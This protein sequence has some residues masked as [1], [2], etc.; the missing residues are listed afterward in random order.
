[1]T[2]RDRASGFFRAS[3]ANWI[4]WLGWIVVI[5]V[6]LA[7]AIAVRE[8]GES[9]FDAYHRLPPLVRIGLPL[10]V[11]ALLLKPLYL[12]VIRRHDWKSQSGRDAVAQTILEAVRRGDRPRYAVYLRSFWLD[13]KAPT[14]YTEYH[15]GALR[16]APMRDFE[17]V[18]AAALQADTPLIALG[19]TGEALGSGKIETT[20]GG[21]KER[22]KLLC[23]HATT[24]YLVPLDTESTRWET[25]TLKDEG[26]LDKTVFIMPPSSGLCFRES[27]LAGK[28]NAARQTYSAIGIEIPEYCEVGQ[29]FCLDKSGRLHSPECV[30]GGNVLNAPE[31]MGLELSPNALRTQISELLSYRA[32]CAT[33]GTITTSKCCPKCFSTR[34]KTAKGQGRDLFS[35][36]SYYLRVCENCG[37]AYR[38]PASFLAELGNAVVVCLLSLTLGA[39]CAVLFKS[40][41]DEYISSH[42]FPGMIVV[43][44]VFC[45]AGA[46]GT[47]VLACAKGCEALSLA[48]SSD[49]SSDCKAR[50]PQ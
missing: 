47:L 35:M 27:E 15:S 17:Y 2:K 9:M 42:R 43:F 32:T 14:E 33:A 46:L 3:T 38:W 22:A 4:E 8:P 37:E 23:L 16:D 50:E 24:I 21:W 18:L 44:G 48:K 26:L 1:M 31:H 34:S 6:G 10:A 5:C 7:I 41:W 11:V 29:L 49:D 12:R 28:W 20:D 30:V 19:R 39:L 36:F 13:G 45:G 25:T 40:A